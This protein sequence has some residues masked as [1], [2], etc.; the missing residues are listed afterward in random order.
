MTLPCSDF[1]ESK[2]YLGSWCKGHH[3]L[4]DRTYIILIVSIL[5]FW[6]KPFRPL[7][8]PFSMRTG[9]CHLHKVRLQTSRQSRAGLSYFSRGTLP[10]P[11]EKK[12]HYASRYDV[13]RSLCTPY[14]GPIFLSFRVDWEIPANSC[15]S[16]NADAGSMLLCVPA[17]PEKCIFF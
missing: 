16:F 14:A 6:Q 9:S 3:H 11:V 2:V 13:L 12:L 15:R 4:L 1:L 17:R 7:I 10:A 5:S 8:D